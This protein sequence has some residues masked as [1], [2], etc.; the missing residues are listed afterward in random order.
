MDAKVIRTRLATRESVVPAS[1]PSLAGVARAML[2]L[3]GEGAA[4]AG[5]AQLAVVRELALL[6]LHHARLENQLAASA[7]ELE[8]YAALESEMS[9]RISATQ[10]E[11]AGLQSALAESQRVRRRKEAEEALAQQVNV[12]APRLATQASIEA[13]EAELA[14]LRQERERV[15][16]QFDLRRRQFQLL[17]HS[18]AEL[19]QSL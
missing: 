6:E 5:A 4:G 13:V 8:E 19:S 7:A 10:A 1:E 12:E 3:L 2:A 9:A 18:I 17:I 16:Q 14:V 15:E 11:I